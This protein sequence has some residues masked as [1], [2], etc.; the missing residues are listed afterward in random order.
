MENAPAL[1]LAGGLTSLTHKLNLDFGSSMQMI[2]VFLGGVALLWF[3]VALEIDIRLLKRVNM[4][5][6]LLAECALLGI[7]FISVPF[8]ILEWPQGEAILAI[9]SET[10]AVVLI[11]F[12]GIRSVRFVVASTSR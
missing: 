2:A 4:G 12:C 9:G 6:L 10:W 11:A 5:W 7:G 1:I 8:G 3:L